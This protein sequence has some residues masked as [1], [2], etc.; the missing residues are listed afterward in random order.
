MIQV[1]Q[2]PWIFLLVFALVSAA[3]LPAW[4]VVGPFYGQALTWLVRSGCVVLGYPISF[5]TTYPGAETINPGMLAG[6]ALFGATPNRG[7]RWKLTWV[8]ALILLL[9]SAQAV[10]L[11][12]QVH[13]AVA[14]LA[15]EAQH[16]RP[17]LAI[18][19]PDPQSAAATS[20][21]REA[22]Y[23]LSPLMTAGVWLTAGR[24]F[25]P[26]VDQSTRPP[27]SDRATSGM[28]VRRF[29]KDRSSLG[30]VT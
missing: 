14:D 28:S 12:A 3:L 29:R 7:V 30:P 9:A 26:L 15:A 13:S 8:G 21:L 27:P 25:T 16:L 20:S 19:A 24:D 10:L 22:W 4:E 2:R 18:D 23:W 1:P 6:I 5:G 17:W 11:V